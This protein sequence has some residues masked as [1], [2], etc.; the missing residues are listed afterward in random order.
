[1]GWGELQKYVYILVFTKHIV[2]SVW[3]SKANSDVYF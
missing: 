1:M 3:K 2:G